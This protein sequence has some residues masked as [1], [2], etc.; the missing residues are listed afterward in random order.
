MSKCPICNTEFAK[1]L[2]PKAKRMDGKDKDQENDQ[3][4]CPT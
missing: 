4:Q 3:P 1:E 2:S